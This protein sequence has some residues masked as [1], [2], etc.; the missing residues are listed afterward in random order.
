ES[1][2]AT[3][4]KALAEGKH[5]EAR[6][7]A[8]QVLRGDPQKSEALPIFMRAAAGAADSRLTMAAREYLAQK[9]EDKADRTFAWDV[10]SKQSPM[11]IAG[12]SWMLL[13]EDERK[14]PDF[15]V[16]WLERLNSENLG[17]LVDAELAKQTRQTD[18]R[19]ERIRL[20]QLNAQATDASHRE[21]QA[22]LLDRIASHPDE[23][24]MLLGVM[25]EI[26]QSA[27][28]PYFFTALGKWIEGRGDK[29]T[30]EDQ[31]RLARCEIAAHPDSKDAVLARMIST[32]GNSHPVPVAKLHASFGRFEKAK[33]LLEP[34]LTQGDPDAFKWM[35]T[36]LERLG[37]LE[38]WNKL[39]ENPPAGVPLAEV[40]CDRAYIA[41]KQGD[42]RV[43]TEAEQKALAAA[44][45]EAKSDSL[46]RLARHAYDRG[47]VDYSLE[48]WIKAIQRGSA[49]PLPFFHSIDPVIRSAAFGKKENP[50]FDMLRIYRSLEPGNADVA[51]QFSYLG[52]LLGNV[53]PATLIKELSPVRERLLQ[54]PASI[55][56]LALDCTIALAHLLEGHPERAAELTGGNGIDW[57][58][59]IPAHRVI[60]AI[61]LTKTGRQEEAEVYLEGFDWDSLLPSETRVFRE[62]LEV[63]VEIDEAQIAQEAGKSEKAK[64]AEEARQAQKA[65]E[66]EE[67][68]KAL[69]A[70]DGEKSE[71]TKIAEKAEKA[72]RARLAEEA[73]QAKRNA[74]LKEIREKLAERAAKEANPEAPATR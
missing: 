24:P 10:L 71:E 54:D 37:K 49:S 22:R 47:L 4:K 31:M 16:P 44:E 57:F 14:D 64:L 56:T 27:L 55:K 11:G 13:R 43:Q 21:L 38:D 29:A 52:C 32:H 20:S 25:D 69:E 42:Q 33:E 6:D 1:D 60:R 28:I 70:K 26:P 12:M 51:I 40:W 5:V 35:A 62:L 36:A 19:V 34:T 2:L 74:E 53:P 67:I 61:A 41:A 18:P 72:E 59:Q 65:K 30:V 8:L 17:Q 46:I 73:R 3:A 63:P 9:T 45:L 58:N 23:G 50:L 48:T 68:R 15:L 66:L 39:L 7:F